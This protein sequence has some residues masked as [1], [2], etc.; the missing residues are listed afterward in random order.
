MAET[1]LSALALLG[2]YFAKLVWPVHLSAFYVFRVSQ[3][4]WEPQVLAGVAA[5]MVCALAFAALWKKSR[6]ASFGIIW[7]LATLGPV[8]NAGWMGP[9]VQADRYLYLPSVGFCLT[10]GWAVAALWRRAFEGKLVWRWAAAA[11]MCLV[12]GFC[13]L[14]IVTRI[15]DWRDDVTLISRT[16]GD[17]PNEFILHDALGDA[18]WIRGEEAPAEHEWKV[19]L[20]INPAF[21]RPVNALGALYAKERRYGEAE[22]YLRRATRLTPGDAIAHMNLGSLYAETG[23]PD[24]AEQ[25]F[26][27]AVAAAPMNFTAHNLLGK[28]YFDSNRLTEAEQQFRQ[29]LACEPN[30][31]AYDH[32]GY[33]Y[34]RSAD[35]DRAEQAFR[36]ALAID[37]SDSHAHFNLGLIYAATGRNAQAAEELQ[38][39]LAADPKNLEIRTALEK[40]RH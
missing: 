40:L 26:Q 39:A 10:V 36:A 32:L 37:P 16:L 19:A 11:G 2:Q 22:E 14:R 1:L 8:L 33:I 9:Y 20:Q 27:A 13:I 3:K 34:S 21:V 35:R 6:P 28:V 18:Y 30:L 38:A 23:K 15:P 7:L 17:E 4:L 5:L 25:E 24:R 12:A 31:A 29:S